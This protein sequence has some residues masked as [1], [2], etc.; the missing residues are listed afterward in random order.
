MVSTT[1]FARNNLAPSYFKSI[2]L[3]RLATVFNC[4]KMTTKGIHSG[5]QNRLRLHQLCSKMGAGKN[6]T[7]QEKGQIEAYTNANWSQRKIVPALGRDKKAVHNHQKLMKQLS[8]P[9]KQGRKPKL[10]D[11][12]L[13]N[14][15][16]K[17]RSGSSSARQ[18][19]SI[20]END[21][22]VTIGIR[23]MQQIIS[24]APFMKSL[25]MLK[26]PKIS[27]DNKSDRVKWALKYMKKDHDFCSSVIF[28][29][30]KRFCLERSDGN[31]HYWADTRL[32]RKYFSTR[33]RGGHGLMIWA[34]ISKK[35]K[36]DL[37]FVNGNLND[38]AY[39]TMLT[40]HFLPFIEDK[41]GGEGDQA[42]FQQDNA[43]AHSAVHT[44]EWFFS[45]IVSVLDWPAKSP[46]LNVIEN[47]WTWIVRDVYQGQRQFDY[48]DDLREAIIDAWDRMPQTYIDTL[49]NSMPARCGSVV[50]SRGGPTKYW[51]T[52]IAVISKTVLNY[53]VRNKWC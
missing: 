7:E 16:Q 19:V 33:A 2:K 30:E 20:A 43:P 34:A 4:D 32:E 3:S 8:V 17:A 23:R 41:H 45:N 15:I 51:C 53:F 5:L 9:K 52:S 11:R 40:D 21:F 1:Y 47:A 36:S 14:L 37:V 29:D 39:T 28:S 12:M 22:G 25:K 42:I 13:R 24:E 48:V 44:K 31:A 49:I 26:A 38:Q 6:L 10:S 46:D 35:G 27:V 50:L 18:L